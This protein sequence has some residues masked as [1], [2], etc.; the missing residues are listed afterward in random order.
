[1]PDIDRA[2][3]ISLPIS[4]FIQ[5]AKV[6]FNAQYILTLKRVEILGF[7]RKYL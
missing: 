4:Q 6:A 2:L 1:M 7:A 3:H 5:H